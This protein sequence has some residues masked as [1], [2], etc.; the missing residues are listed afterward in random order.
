MADTSEER[1]PWLEA[2]EQDEDGSP[3]VSL[4]KMAM[5]AVLVLVALGALAATSFWFGREAG[6]GGEPELIAAPDTPYKVKPEDPGGLD[7]SEESGTAFATSAGEDPDSRLD[8]SRMDQPQ[9]RIEVEEPEPAAAAPDPEPETPAP[10][11]GNTT[12]QLGAYSSV[13]LAETGWAVLSGGYAEV[14][15]LEKVIV[16]ATV[17]GRRLF[18]LRARG[19]RDQ[20]RSACAALDAAGE[21]CVIVN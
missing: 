14:A 10:T 9:T 13:A 6:P 19:S 2:V 4:A 3:P 11:G 21:S 7:L 20:A 16:P 8:T 17:N 5:G 15:A 12:V 1:L 18:R